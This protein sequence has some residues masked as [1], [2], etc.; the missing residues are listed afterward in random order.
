MRIGYVFS[1]PLPSPDADTLQVLKMVDALAG[2]GADVELVVSRTGVARRGG[3]RAFAEEL[4]AFYALRSP[5]R[6]AV[7]SGPAP[8]QARRRAPLALAR[9]ERGSA[10]SLR[11]GLQPQPFGS[12]VCGAVGNARAVRNVS[13]ARR[14][15]SGVRAASR[16]ARAARLAGRRDRALAYQPRRRLQG[17]A[18]PRRGWP[19]STTGTIRRTSC[20]GFRAAK[21]ALRSGSRWSGRCAAMRAASVLAKASKRCSN[22]RRSHRGSRTCSQAAPRTTPR[23]RGAN[24][25]AADSRTSRCSTSDRSRSWRRACT[26]R[27]FCWCRRAVRSRAR[28]ARCCRS[29]CSRTS[30]P[31]GRSWR[32][33]RTTSASCWLTARTRG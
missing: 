25:R 4:Q 27:T 5:P 31:G 12:G 8:T 6:I 24:A 16:A 20:R 13:A 22:S 32:P 23:A 1:R 2:E 26:P 18:F 33:P 10:A 19:R 28:G 14:R 30:Q 3:E 29:S 17:A 15:E 9:G 7:V 11:R 21:R